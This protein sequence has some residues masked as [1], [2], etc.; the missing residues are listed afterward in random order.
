[1]PC[2]SIWHDPSVRTGGDHCDDDGD[3]RCRAGGVFE[4]YAPASCSGKYITMENS[5]ILPDSADWTLNLD[6]GL[7][8]RILNA[9]IF[10]LSDARSNDAG[11]SAFGRKRTLKIG[12]SP[13]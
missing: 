8:G 3:N 7:V 2:W 12:V 1:M 6:F 4:L 13:G 5:T 9:I 11:M 10:A